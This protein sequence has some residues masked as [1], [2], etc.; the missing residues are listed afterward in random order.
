MRAVLHKFK[1]SSK[2]KTDF[3]FAD[4]QDYLTRGIQSLTAQQAKISTLQTLKPYLAARWDEKKQA[5]WND[6]PDMDWLFR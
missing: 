1:Q 2:K 4:H 3:A 6:E 5:M